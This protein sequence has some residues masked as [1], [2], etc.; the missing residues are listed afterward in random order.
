MWRICSS[1]FI[2]SRFPPIGTSTTRP[3]ALWRNHEVVKL[4]TNS[5][6]PQA[7]GDFQISKGAFELPTV[8]IRTEWRTTIQKEAITYGPKSSS[9]TISSGRNPLRSQARR[10]ISGSGLRIWTRLESTKSSKRSRVDCG[11]HPFNQPRNASSNSGVRTPEGGVARMLLYDS[12]KLFVTATKRY[13]LEAE[14][15]KQKCNVGI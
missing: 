14:G 15:E 13:F 2:A 5:P 3:Q 9:M 8:I 10:K 4:L 6:H 7:P 1:C 12:V 11:T